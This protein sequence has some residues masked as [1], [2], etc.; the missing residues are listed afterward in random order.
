MCHF[1]CL[2]SKVRYSAQLLTD[3]TSTKTSFNSDANFTVML[4]NLLMYWL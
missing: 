4:A 3:A 1:L 2:L